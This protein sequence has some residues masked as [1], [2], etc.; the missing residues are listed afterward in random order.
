MGFIRGSLFVIVAT[1]FFIALLVMNSTLVVSFSLDYENIREDL[2]PVVKETLKENINLTSVIDTKQYPLMQQFCKDP[3]QQL[4]YTFSEQNYS[5]SVSCGAISNGTE[6]VFDEVIDKFIYEQYYK[7]YSCGYW[8][9]FKVGQIP[10]FIVSQYSKDYWQK[11]FYFSLL[12][13]L[14]L[15]GLMFLL[16]E[17]KTNL[18]LV[19]GSLV[20]LSSLLFAKLE[21][22]TKWAINAL[23]TLPISPEEYLRFFTL[24][25]TQSSKVFIIMLIAGLVL[26]AI[27]I[28]LKF[29]AIGFKINEFFSKFS[30]KT[31]ENKVTENKPNKQKDKDG[32][33]RKNSFK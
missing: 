22:L 31:K 30:S 5:F 19:A 14:V 13:S 25:F 1:C 23:L 18:P 9:C 33:S 28:I 32:S 16:I 2:L 26:L 11:Q 15:L 6:T 24:I 17:K 10:F 3:S 29:F 4:D 7:E 12:I 20:V 21:A 8:K 27:G